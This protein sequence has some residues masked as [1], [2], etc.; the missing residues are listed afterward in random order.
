M[1]DEAKTVNTGAP[2]V[3]GTV[4]PLRNVMRLNEL[5]QS[6][7]DR[8]A[9]LPGMACFY[10]PSGYGKSMAATW[11]ANRFK[12]YWV[13]VKSTWSRKDLTQKIL[14][15]MRIPPA[16]TLG[17]MV[18]Q[19][20]EQLL[21]SGRPLLIDEADEVAKEGMIKVIRDIYEGSKG[22]IILIGEESLP[23]KLRKWERIHNRQYDWVA[24]EPADLREVGILAKLK[25]PGLDLSDDL[26]QLIL[27]RSHGRARRIVTNLAHVAEYA[28]R[29]RRSSVGL[30]DASKIRFASGDAPAPRVAV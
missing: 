1:L 6:V 22:T 30:E 8:D 28:L 18:E 27:D 16:G 7:N 25:C 19:I 20:G 24:A 12:G 17:A 14:K 11:N 5:I 10:G 21:K 13:E 3:A 23:Q 4:A 2:A 15:Q 26:K 9:D 29:T